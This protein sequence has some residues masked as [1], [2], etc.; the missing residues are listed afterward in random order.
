MR[1]QGERGFALL[2]QRWRI[3]QHVTTCPQKI[4]AIANAALILTHFETQIP[5]LTEITSIDDVIGNTY[6]AHGTS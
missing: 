4:G 5:Y 1:C 2:T 6:H 3:L